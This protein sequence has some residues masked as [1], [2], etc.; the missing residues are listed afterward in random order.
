MAWLSCSGVLEGGSSL[1]DCFINIRVATRRFPRRLRPWEP[2]W[3]AFLYFSS[4][5]FLLQ[6]FLCPFLFLCLA[7]LSFFL[8]FSPDYFPSFPLYFIKWHVIASLYLFFSFCSSLFC[9][10]LF[11]AFCLYLLFFLSFDV[12]PVC[13]PFLSIPLFPSYQSFFCWINCYKSSTPWNSVT[14]I[15]WRPRPRQNLAESKY[16]ATSYLL[17]WVLEANCLR[18]ANLFELFFWGG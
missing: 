1:P 11:A 13:I 15:R 16:L 4:F 17:Y 5:C 9:F 3:K 8:V 12:F 18:L 7:V 6:S 14:T 10:F 2:S